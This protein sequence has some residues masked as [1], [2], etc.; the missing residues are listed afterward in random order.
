[1]HLLELISSPSYLQV[2]T[3]IG[4]YEDIYIS[5][6]YVHPG[7]GMINISSETARLWLGRACVYPRVCHRITGMSHKHRHTMLE[8]NQ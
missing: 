1:M 3:S 7:K 8:A 2:L 6:V 4:V 5:P